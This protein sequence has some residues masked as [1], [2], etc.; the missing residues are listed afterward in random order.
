MLSSDPYR[1]ILSREIVKESLNNAW[2]QVFKEEVNIAH[3]TYISYHAYAKIGRV[4]KNTDHDMTKL[5]SEINFFLIHI[6]ESLSN[7]YHNREIQSVRRS[8]S[9]EILEMC[10]QYNIVNGSNWKELHKQLSI[11]ITLKE[12]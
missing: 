6:N 9:R 7:F 10:S 11:T 8:F 2:K 1:P 5:A 4:A 12:S 3:S